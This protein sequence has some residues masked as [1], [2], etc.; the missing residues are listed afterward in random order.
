MKK[1]NLIL[2]AILASISVVAQLPGSLDESYAENGIATINWPGKITYL[3]QTG[4]QSNDQVIVAGRY[5]FTTFGTS[6]S[7]VARLNTEGGLDSFGNHSNYYQMDYADS[8]MITACDVLPDDGII[9]AGYYSS[10][11]YAFVFK[12]DSEGVLDEEFGDEG[13]FTITSEEHAIL[14]IATYPTAEG[15]NILL[16]GFQEAFI[17]EM[18]MLNQDGEVVSSFGVD[19][20]Y[21]F[22]GSSGIYRHMAID[23]NAGYIYACGYDISS[24]SMFIS[25]HNIF[26]GT[27]LP[28]FGTGGYVLI[29]PFGD[30]TEFAIRRII[31][32]PDG[33]TISIFGDYEH[34]DGDSDLF[35][36]RLKTSDGSYDNA[37]GLNGWSTLR[38]PASTERLYAAA[39]QSNGQ[40]YIGGYVKNENRDY[41][42]GRISND[43]FLDNGFGV[44]GFSVVDEGLNECITMISLS[45]DESRVFCSGNTED[46]DYEDMQ[47]LC[48][49]TDFNNGVGVPSVKEKNRE[50]VLF[51]NPVHNI[52]NI[53]YTGV[54]GPELEMLNLDGRILLTT[55]LVQGSSQINVSDI[56]PGLYILRI[57]SKI[58]ISNYKFIKQ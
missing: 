13:S 48:F 46:I 12:L 23:T 44:N 40:F 2:L 29:D 32:E 4:I 17:P 7:I 36:F 27:L 3:S 55:Q 16:C 41:L 53:E 20:I 8:E 26:N 42:L 43:G 54:G 37:F 14:D 24:G 22:P 9:A 52:L 47:V 38:I 35:A 25:A 51:P 39:R 57:K 50:L 21:H 56:I 31:L 34:M 19:G 15:Y 58:Q 33:N 11:N 45:A 30:A 5:T 1:T 6:N 28:T 49:F 18:R 10:E